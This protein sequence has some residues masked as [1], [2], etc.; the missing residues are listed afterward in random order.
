[1]LGTAPSLSSVDLAATRSLPPPALFTGASPTS[2][3][4]LAVAPS[5]S[6]VDQATGWSLPPPSRR[7]G[8]K[9][10]S[11][12]VDLEHHLRGFGSTAAMEP[13]LYRG[14]FS[15]APFL[16]LFY[17][18]SGEPRCGSDE[19]AADLRS[20]DHHLWMGSRRAAQLLTNLLAALPDDVLSLAWT[21][22][23][24]DAFL[25]CLEE[26]RALL[27][28]SGDAPTARPPLDRLVTDFFD[29]AVK[30]LDLCNAVRD[31]LDL[32]RQW[33]K[34][35][36]I[37]LAV[38]ASSSS[39]L[40]LGEAQIRRARKALID[41]TI[42]MLD[43]RDDEGVVG[44]RNRSFGHPANATNEKGA[45]GHDQGHHRW[46]SSGG[47]PARAPPTGQRHCKRV[48]RGSL[49]NTTTIRFTRQTNIESLSMAHN[50]Q[51]IHR[52]RGRTIPTCHAILTPFKVSTNKLE[53]IFI[54]S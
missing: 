1:M 13:S 28:S 8:S 11:F 21:R 52:D 20:G 43:D 40:S 24:V 30:A 6:G 37:A 16:P 26:F 17:G 47:R 23:L 50:T 3:A 27:F 41:L 5:F 4:A 19:G 7:V 31:R 54:L 42:L 33:R 53:N 51:P 9:P 12:G 34:H 44:Q 32:V 48:F 22:S 49:C 45:R 15:P 38:L 18:R 39:P 14:G 29:C 2:S 46:S 10:S 36:A 25:L 35:L